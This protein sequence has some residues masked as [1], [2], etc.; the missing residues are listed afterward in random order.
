MSIKSLKNQL[1]RLKK[2]VFVSTHGAAIDMVRKHWQPDFSGDVRQALGVM[3]EKTL[4]EAERLENRDK[5]E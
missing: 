2:I 1:E 4:E 5:E 3:H